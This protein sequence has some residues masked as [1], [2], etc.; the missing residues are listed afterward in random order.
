MTLTQLLLQTAVTFVAASIGAIFGAF[1]TRR[2]EKFKHLQELRS[3]AYADFVRGVATAAEQSQ[4]RNT[5]TG[6]KALVAD[7][8][9]RIVIYGG[10]DVISALCKFF[11]LGGQTCNAEGMLAFANL[12]RSMRAETG[13]EHVR[14]EDISKVL[15]G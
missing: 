8:R 11:A 15:F 12:C 13:H 10:E 1:L 3:A 2:T 14:A 6:S 4:A 9:A 7:A 5:A